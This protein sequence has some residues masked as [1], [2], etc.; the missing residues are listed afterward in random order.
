MD[1]ED[2]LPEGGLLDGHIHALVGLLDDLSR[3]PSR[4]SSDRGVVLY[5]WLFHLCG[6]RDAKLVTPPGGKTKVTLALYKTLDKRAAEFKK[7]LQSVQSEARRPGATAAT[8]ARLD[9]HQ[10]LAG[11]RDLVAECVVRLRPSNEQA[12]AAA[13]AATAASGGG[14]SDPA[15]GSDAEQQ[16]HTAALRAFA[17]GTHERLG[18]GYA[19]RE[20]P[21]AVRRLR[22]D[23]DVLGLIADYVRGR[24]RRTLEPPPREVQVLRVGMWHEHREKH[25]WREL[26]EERG[27]QLEQALADATRAIRREAHTQAEATTLREQFDEYRRELQADSTA[28]RA[29]VERESERALK[30]QRASA[31]AA[32][33]GQKRKFTALFSA[34]RERAERAEADVVRAKEDK[35]GDR[36]ETLAR[37]RQRE[38]EASAARA[39]VEQALAELEQQHTAQLAAMERLRNARNG[40]ALERQ[41]ALEAE[42]Q[43]LKA[44]RKATQLK[45]SDANLAR[46]ATAVAQQQLQKERTVLRDFWGSGLDYAARAKEIE[47]ENAALVQKLKDARADLKAAQGE[48]AKYKAVAEPAKAKFF[49]AG[50]FSAAVDQVIIECLSLGVAR[51]KLPQLF[52]IF[53]RF[54]G[55]L[56]PGRKK[57]V[58]GP[59]VDGRRTTVK[60][61][62]YYLPGKSHVKEMAAVMNQLNKLHVGEWLLQHI[63]SDETS[64]CYLA[65]GAES[66]QVD[67]LGQLL[68]RRVNG[69][70]DIKA[71]SLDALGS[72]TADAQAAAFR[73]SLGEMADL[74]LKAG[75]VDNRAAELIRR[76]MPTC[77]QN[78]RASAARAAARKALGLPEGENDP[79]CAE[80]ALVNILEEGRKAMDR[81]LREMMN[82]SDE[83][84]EG[85]AAKVKAMRTCVGWFSSPACAL[86]YQV[87]DYSSLITNE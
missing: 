44:R 62:V 85:D 79:T 10:Q 52:V 3:F 16:R 34:E 39:Q 41:A 28:W 6:G 77:S 30:E 82:I 87:T 18:A 29:A 76:F 35:E 58:P 8:L 20:E 78:D 2:Y 80:H 60:R 81:V 66:Q 63:E 83:Q 69:K 57:K 1:L 27:V 74:M 47:S 38:L 5:I 13:A 4:Q 55:I 51:N 22:N 54:H 32:L 53:A 17:M 46:R 84:A 37:Y 72:K 9:A 42:V 64:C 40:S 67:Y 33:R 75:L 12:A 61:Y 59:W 43:R 31:A 48:A 71:L 23:H 25:S 70:L 65:D 45:V 21:C 49:E 68:A 56:I 36:R 11:Q 26:A 86:I 7:K 24:P 19:S 15:P 73:A 50:H 14:D